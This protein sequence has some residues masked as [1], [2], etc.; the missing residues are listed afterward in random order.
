MRKNKRR[1]LKRN[2]I[3]WIELKEKKNFKH[4][5][6]WMADINLPQA[7]DIN[8]TKIKTFLW[9]RIYRTDWWSVGWLNQKIFFF[10]I[11]V[12][13]A[14]NNP[15]QA[16]GVSKVAETKPWKNF[17]VFFFVF[18]PVSL[19][20]VTIVDGPCRRKLMFFWCDF[21]IFFPSL[22]F[23]LVANFN[24]IYKKKNTLI[25]TLFVGLL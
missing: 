15:Q 13:I 14:Q 19:P 12:V 2:T 16:T 10:L 23:F 7:V 24:S 8:E 9:S 6:Q 17:K 5:P 18:S 25:A 21:L 3:I 11:V 20:F 22:Q 4:Q 1:R